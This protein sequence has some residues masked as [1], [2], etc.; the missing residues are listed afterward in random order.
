MTSDNTTDL[1]MFALYTMRVSKLPK[2]F[3]QDICVSC[4]LARG[5]DNRTITVRCQTNIIK[6]LEII[7]Q[8]YLR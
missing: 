5:R 3:Y 8:L 6:D 1:Y 7:K 2:Q 4:D